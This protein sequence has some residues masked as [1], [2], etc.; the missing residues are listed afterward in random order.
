MSFN[1][2]ILCGSRKIQTFESPK[3]EVFH[4]RFND[5]SEYIAA[6]SPAASYHCNH[7]ICL[8]T[9]HKIECSAD[10]AKV[11]SVRHSNHFI[12]CKNPFKLENVRFGKGKSVWRFKTKNLSC[13]SDVVFNS[14]S[15]IF[16]M[17]SSFCSFRSAVFEL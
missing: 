10:D 15:K 11:L 9:G 1:V 16:S 13:S 4:D 14:C 12:P 3:S 5:M 17:Y 2:P 7:V 6:L 8:S